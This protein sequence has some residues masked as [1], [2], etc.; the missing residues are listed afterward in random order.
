[1]ISKYQFAKA[2]AEKIVDIN[3]KELSSKVKTTT[4]AGIPLIV[5]NSTNQQRNDWCSTE[6][7]FGKAEAYNLE[8]ADSKG[9]ILKSQFSNATYFDDGSIKSAT[10]E[11][12]ATN[13]PSIGYNTLYISPLKTKPANALPVFQNTV[14]NSFY[15]ITFANGGLSSIFDK[16]LNQELVDP[17]KFKAGEVFT[18]RSI[19]NGAGEFSDI[20]KPDMEGYD[21]T[22]NYQ[23]KWEIGEDGPVY[24]CYK[25]R[26]P[27]R[28][29]VVEQ[30]IKLFHQQKRIDFETALLN[31]EGVLYRE[32]RMA[33]P[34]NMTDGQVAYEV[35]FGVVEV[36]KSEMEGAAGER[37]QTTCKDVHPR[38]I[39]NWISS[40]NSKFGVTMSSSVVVNDWIDPT[41]NPAKNQ[42]LQPILL[43]S[44]KSCHWEGNDYLQ[45]GN[46]TFRFSITSHQPGWQN[47]CIFGRQANEKLLTVQATHPFTNASLPETMSFLKANQESILISTIKKAE[48]SDEV[49]IRLA[50][51]NGKDQNTEI[52]MYQNIRQAK[53]A[54]L[55][56]TDIKPLQVQGN[57]LKLSLGHN[58]IETIKIK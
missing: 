15:K 39:E 48:D 44:R 12:M 17:S 8:V 18:M 52:E 37:Y 43:A 21:K 27:I 34:L 4:S 55:I 47:G 7:T 54:N 42:I 16:E 46:H 35:P 58:A 49:V 56:E 14:E 31:W 19:G 36:G 40:S 57:R 28:Y 5:F 11:I 26:Q 32:F 41:N 1:M 38:G 30:R 3:L 33:L 25:Y 9:S 29:A 13:I 10:L 50:E 23:T 51:M 53:Q 6:L 24:T 22:G 20:Q 2:E 45:T